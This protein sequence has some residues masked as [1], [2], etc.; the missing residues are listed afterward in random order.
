MAQ[1][2]SYVLIRVDKIFLRII[3]VKVM[4]YLNECKSV[5]ELKETIDL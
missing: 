4:H 2:M 5:V 3:T 1:S